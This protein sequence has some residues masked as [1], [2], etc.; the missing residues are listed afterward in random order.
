MLPIHNISPPPV[1]VLAELT[2]LFAVGTYDASMSDVNA[3][4]CSIHYVSDGDSDGPSVV[5]LGELGLGPWQWAWQYGRLPGR[6]QTV[7]IDTRGCGR[8]DAP[9]GPYA[10]KG[11]VSDLEAVLNDASIRK[12]HL[13][14]CGL[15]GCVALGAARQTNRARSLTLINTPAAGA[16]LNPTDLAADPADS[17]A[18]RE[19]T[20]ALFSDTFGTDAPGLVDQIV[21]WRCDEDA[22]PAARKAQQATLGEF[23][24]GALYELTLPALVVAGGQDS[25]V[26]PDQ[27]HQLA[28]D[29]PRGRFQR[30]PDVGHFPTIERAT[31]FTDELVAF[32]ESAEK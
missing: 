32:V 9:D 4:G 13:V 27:S 22:E 12:A 20:N 29:L 18:V 14:G 23:N 16:D 2:G 7:V 6:F 31:A 21:E 25:V 19:S 11:L 15:G 26:S 17:S 24:A 10:M 8:S 28:D 5:F 30:F 3:G 1:T